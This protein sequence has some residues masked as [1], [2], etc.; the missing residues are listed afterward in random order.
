MGNALL[1]LMLSAWEADWHVCRLAGAPQPGSSNFCR[2]ITKVRGALFQ[3][4]AQTCL[5]KQAKAILLLVAICSEPSAKN[6]GLDKSVSNDSRSE[7]W[8]RHPII[9]KTELV[10]TY[11]SVPLPPP[12]PRPPFCSPSSSPFCSPSCSPFSLSLL[13]FLL[14]LLLLFSPPPLAP[15]LSPPPPPLS[16]P[17]LSPRP[18]FS[19]NQCNQKHGYLSYLTT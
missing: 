11:I 3:C 18:K 10:K 6:R 9:F 8:K 12:P 17:P 19:S 14:L 4:S 13:L 16:P 7:S 5:H 15:P 1:L 2:Q